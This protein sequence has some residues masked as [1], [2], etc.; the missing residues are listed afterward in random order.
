M[1]D[2]GTVSIHYRSHKRVTIHLAN[3]TDHS[4]LVISEVRITGP[5]TR[6]GRDDGNGWREFV[7]IP[8]ANILSWE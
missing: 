3:G 5:I 6:F 1:D 4:N 7:A 2:E 8:T